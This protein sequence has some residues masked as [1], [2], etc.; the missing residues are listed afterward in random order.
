MVVGDLMKVP[1]FEL[2]RAIPYG[3]AVFEGDGVRLTVVLANHL[4][5]EQQLG[6][7]LIYYN[8]TFNAFVIVQYKAMERTDDGP[9]FR[10]PDEQLAAELDR[11]EAALTALK[12]CPPNVER[13]G[14]RLLDNPFYLKLCP[15][16][17]FN[18]DD[19]G[20]VPGMYLPFDYWRLI[21][22]DPS[23][24][25]PRGGRQITFENVGRYLDNTRFV[26]LVGKAWIGT[27]IEQSAVLRA[28]I[29]EVMRSGRVL[30]LA[31][32]TETK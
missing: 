29:R 32:K 13:R 18:P 27:T 25:G 7:D 8:E 11:M 30:A 4:P 19:I 9:V 23:L 2:L 21:E 12:T 16:V 6:A 1:G 15:R 24:V 5:L 20:L 28:V 22:A 26:D 10:L 3:A 14:F 31:V 17:G